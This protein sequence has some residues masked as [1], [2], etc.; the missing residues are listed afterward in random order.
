MNI[1]SKREVGRHSAD[2]SNLGIMR[3]KVPTRHRIDRTST[4]FSPSPPALSENYTRSEPTRAR[5]P[6]KI[7]SSSLVKGRRNERSRVVR[8]RADK[9]SWKGWKRGRDNGGDCTKESRCNPVARV[10]GGER[11][12]YGE[13]NE[14]VETG[15]HS[16]GWNERHL[17]VSS[18]SEGRVENNCPW[19]IWKIHSRDEQWT[20][21]CLILFFFL[22]F[23]LFK[24]E[25]RERG[26]RKDEGKISE[27][28]LL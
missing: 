16:A 17:D 5:E 25:K 18:S 10:G 9:G 21:I 1:T 8:W 13:R 22:F 6:D 7:S 20:R 23:D 28:R 11:R 24:T 4:P 12:G 26:K 19:R 27:G 2:R 15:F 14:S 3:G